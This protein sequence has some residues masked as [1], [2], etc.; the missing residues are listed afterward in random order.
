[1]R[2]EAVSPARATWAATL[3]AIASTAVFVAIACTPAQVAKIETGIPDDAV[4][5]GCVV[6]AALGGLSVPA[7]ATRCATD[8]VQV[9][10]IL[11]QAGT[12]KGAATPE[13]SELRARFLASEAYNEALVRHSLRTP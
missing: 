6:G 2:G 12:A 7:I 3:V 9:V 4:L 11:W 1:M 8:A 10:E 13:G 5:L